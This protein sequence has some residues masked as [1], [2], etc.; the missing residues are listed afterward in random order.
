MSSGTSTQDTSS[1][2]VTQIPQWMQQAGQQNYAYAQDVA[3]L[4]L[5]QYQGQMVAG[6]AP[7]TQQAWNLAASS[8]N[9]GGDQYNAST[10][11]DLNAL[12]QTVNP[13][14]A[15]QISGQNLSPYMNPYTQSVIDTTLP[16]MQQANA[17]TQNQQANA[18]NS[19]NAFGGSKQGVQQGVAQAQGALNIGQMAAQLNQ[20]NY[21][22]AQT[23]AG[24]DVA[25]Q[26]AAKMANQTAQQ[27]KINSDILASQGLT[28]TGNSLN[29]ANQQQ[30]NNLMTS[31]ASQSMQAQSEINAQMA[32]FQQAAN[33][34]QQQLGTLLSA[35]GMTPHDTST[36]GESDTT[37]TTPTDWAS[38]LTN[39]LQAGANLWKASDEKIKKNITSLGADP[40]TGVPI[41]SFNF[42][43]QS[44]SAPKIIGPL[45]QDVEKA[46]PGVT[47]R[48]GGV[49]HIPSGALAA[50]TPSIATH[51]RFAGNQPSPGNGLDRLMPTKSALG[52]PLVNARAGARAGGLSNTKRRMPIGALSG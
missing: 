9:V 25:S 46:T 20:A 24:T 14:T 2:S 13:I 47:K 49:L 32:K 42:K 44:A 1:A 16:I 31:G 10:A 35:L 40:L 4:P 28:T 30:F 5:Q 23:A 8:G 21:A 36:T 43:G 52:K 6:V 3:G 41:K 12:G 33:Y 19:A 7:Q 39:G 50:A 51:S 18:A 15:S 27:N 45:A 48:I 17:L 37:T 29:Q 22:Q 26:N 34:P 38:I 11:G